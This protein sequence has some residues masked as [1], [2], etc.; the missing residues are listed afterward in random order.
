MK[1]ITLQ[2][3]SAEIGALFFLASPHLPFLFFTW[4]SKLTGPEVRSLFP[5]LLINGLG[6]VNLLSFWFVLVPLQAI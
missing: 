5:N 2:L 1:K 4:F 3:T 6:G